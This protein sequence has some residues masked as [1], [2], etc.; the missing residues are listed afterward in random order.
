[1]AK[2][3]LKQ[4]TVVKTTEET[5]TPFDVHPTIGS[6]AIGKD[7][8][9]ESQAPR[10][11][12]R[13]SSLVSRQSTGQQSTASMSQ[14]TN[15]KTVTIEEDADHYGTGSIATARP[16]FI[17]EFACA[18]FN[19]KLE[20]VP[21]SST[22]APVTPKW[23]KLAKMHM[24]LEGTGASS[25]QW[26]GMAV[27]A[28]MKLLIVVNTLSAI[29][30]C[31]DS[32]PISK[33]HLQAVELA[34]NFMF[35]VEVVVRLAV[36]PSWQRLFTE[37]SSSQ[38]FLL[39]DAVAALP[40]ALFVAADVAT[41]PR[42]DGGTYGAGAF[43][44][45]CVAPFIRLLKGLRYTQ[46]LC[47]LLT[48]SF[49][50]LCEAIPS[51]VFVMLLILWFFS[52]L[53]MLVEPI[54]NIGSMT[55]AMWMAVITMT[56]IGF[57]DVYPVTQWGQIIVACLAVASLLYMALPIGIIGSIF[58]N[59]WED[60]DRIVV[61]QMIRERLLQW[62]YTALDMPDL[63]NRFD[64]MGHGELD[65]FMFR[66]MIATMFPGYD[67]ARTDQLFKRMD[68][69]DKGTVDARDFTRHLFPK[70]YFELY[71]HR[72]KQ[73]DSRSNSRSASPSP[74][75]SPSPSPY[76]SPEVTG[77]VHTISKRQQS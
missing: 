58:T 65:I 64:P 42:A 3:A 72:S 47:I 49:W 21:R 56:T 45:L 16:S 28:I 13:V 76:A 14:P 11:M 55:Q 12:K 29:G 5:E 70:A 18:L 59:V 62:G 39:I 31:L 2:D 33:E 63:F 23:R 52:S 4:V 51:M 61:K 34:C 27:Q 17:S 8:C 60:R 71:G 73:L 46:N 57:G 75:R 35:A 77:V 10:H 41:P 6:N 37:R 69:Q 26:H 68:H 25:I 15:T 20:F 38:F 9:L 66:E 30:Q 1:V 24:V 44:I 40:F 36:Y 22:G 32:F 7:L 53:I 67:R 43:V 50:L 48:H 19:P 54:E 74:S